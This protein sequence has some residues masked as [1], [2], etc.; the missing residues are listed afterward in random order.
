MIMLYGNMSKSINSGMIKMSKQQ[1]KE[2]TLNNIRKLV[3]TKLEELSKINEIYMAL[4]DL[5][6]YFKDQEISQL[7]I[8]ATE[9]EEELLS[10]LKRLKE[11]LSSLN[12]KAIKKV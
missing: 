2:N 10:I 9:V 1:S 6:S 7:M 8:E 4:G 11:T 3:D 5:E 12:H